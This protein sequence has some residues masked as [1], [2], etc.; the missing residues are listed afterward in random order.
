MT[1]LAQAPQS[2]SARPVAPPVEAGARTTRHWLQA[3][4]ETPSFEERLAALNELLGKRLSSYAAAEAWLHLLRKTDGQ[5]TPQQMERLL[6][7]FLTLAPEHPK[8]GPLFD[9]LMNGPS[10]GLSQPEIVFMITSCVRY[11]P[12][13]RRV[14]RDLRA[15]GATATIVIGDPAQPVAVD[16]PDVATLPV[17]D[18]YEALPHKVLEGLAF[19]RRRHGPG[20][21]IVKVD[22]DMQFSDAL[23]PAA[24]AAAARARDYLGVPISHHGCDRC[25]HLGKTSVPT[26]VFSRRHHGPFAYGPMYALGPRAVEHL[27][28]EWVFYPGE[29]AGHVY[30]DRAIGD[31]LRRGGIDV[32]PMSLE[33]MGGVFEHV[34]R[35]AE[36]A[37]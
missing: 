17:A 28:R 7:Q 22:D 2:P 11:L 37:Y 34:E 25:W 36:P 19:L 35:Y 27:V 29:F 14:Q 30:E 3:W 6:R 9:L 21:S 5:V 8:A 15:R 31:T 1:P 13:A 23:D 24:L 26:P 18:S 16:G 10:A 4:C 12:Q 32:S 20:V 33:E